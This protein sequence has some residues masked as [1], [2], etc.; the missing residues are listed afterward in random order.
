MMKSSLPPIT[1]SHIGA[2]LERRAA[3]LLCLMLAMAACAGD[4]GDGAPGAT[5]AAPSAA[6]EAGCIASGGGFLQ[7]RLRGAFSADVDWSNAH[8]QCE[9][10]SRPDGHGL[11]MTL[12]G[13]L[14]GHDKTLLRFIFGIGFTDVAAGSAQAL[15]TNVTV[16]LE[17]GKQMFA[18]R[19]DDRC[20]VETLERTPLP[21]AGHQDRV[22]V[23]GYC[24]GPAS[25]LAGD[26]RLLIPTFEFTGVVN[27]GDGP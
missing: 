27:T 15:P 11:R 5:A 20:A 8:M 13:P 12:A 4:K 26:S 16:I 23:R 1:G 25:E 7:A 2:G 14:P 18:T 17:G 10:G 9:G 3:A 24:T 21:N 6:A 22:H 19:G